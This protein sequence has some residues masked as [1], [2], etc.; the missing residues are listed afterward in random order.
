LIFFNLFV[1]KKNIAET[2]SLF[3]PIQSN[4]TKTNWILELNKKT[5]EIF[6][7]GWHENSKI[8]KYDAFFQTFETEHCDKQTDKNPRAQAG[9]LASI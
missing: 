4:Q 5:S 2:E 8:F 7:L 3:F 6:Y 9:K 1:K